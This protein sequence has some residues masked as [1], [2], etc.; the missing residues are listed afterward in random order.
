M[1]RAATLGCR[2]DGVQMEPLGS[3]R[4]LGLPAWRGRWQLAVPLS[5]R[6]DS[7]GVGQH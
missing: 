2:G 3:G 6:F 5:A 1:G 7:W 4:D